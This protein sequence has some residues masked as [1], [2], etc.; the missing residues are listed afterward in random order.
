M[1]KVITYEPTKNLVRAF[2][3]IQSAQ[4]E[5]NGHIPFATAEELSKTSLTLDQITA[6]HN[7]LLPEGT[8]PATFADRTAAV[9]AAFPLANKVGTKAATAPTAE[10]KPKAPKAEGEAKPKGRAPGTGTYNGHKL[11]AVGKE[12][13][14]REGSHGAASFQIVLDN[15]GIT[16]E[17]FIAKGGRPQNLR[18]D[19]GANR[20]VAVKPA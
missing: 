7:S 19:I 10:R 6:M 13:P 17:D 16:Y 1:P 2:A 14:R 11:R 9:N 20:I 15:P 12:N 5:G 18:K 3:D 8:A 4:A